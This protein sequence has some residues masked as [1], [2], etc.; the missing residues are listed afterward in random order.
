MLWR[1]VEFPCVLVTGEYG[2]VHHRRP[3]S[4]IMKTQSWKSSGR[5]PTD[6]N[7]KSVKDLVHLL[8]DPALLTSG[9]SLEEPTTT[10]NRIHRMLKLSLSIDEDSAD[11]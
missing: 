7:D 1:V 8:F 10:G 4:S 5:G 9:F 3:W 11:T 2:Y 6:K